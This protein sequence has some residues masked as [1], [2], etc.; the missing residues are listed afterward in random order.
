MKRV[1][2][3]GSSGGNLHRL[4]GADPAQLIRIVQKQL[5]KAGV[6]LKAACFV[7]ADASLDAVTE[8]ATGSLWELHDGA[9]HLVEA[10]RLAKINELAQDQDAAIAELIGSGEVDGV[11]LISADPHGTNQASVAAAAA[12]RLPAAGSGG[13]S[14]AAAE[15]LGIRFVSASGTTGTTNHTRAISYT[16]GFAR[17]W[18]LKYRPVDLPTSPAGWWRR[19]DPRPV[20][21]DALPAI[22]A[23]AVGVGIAQFFGAGTR[24]HLVGLLVPLVLVSISYTASSR[25]GSVGQAGH[26]AGVL[27]GVLA[28]NGGVLTALVAGF[29]AGTLADLAASGAL[30]H[31]V[32]ATG[33]NIIASGGAGLVAGALARLLLSGPGHALDHWCARALSFGLTHAGVWIGAAVGACMWWVL[34]RGYYHSFVL[35]LMVVEFSAGGTSFLAAIDM[36]ALVAVSA[37]VA[38]AAIL[39][40]RTPGDRKPARRTLGIN[41]LLGTYVEG[42]FPHVRAGRAAQAVAVVAATAG[43]AVVGACHGM[44]VTYVP[45]FALPVVGTAH[46]GL[47]AAL[48]VSAG[49]ALCGFATLNLRARRQAV[50]ATTEQHP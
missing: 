1:V 7:S 46:F 41:S 14:V 29:L 48:L 12:H 11:I 43:G 28:S 17:E 35:P 44:G 32:P 30:R 42:S 27:A 34:L 40:P 3:L 6:E 21:V 19:Y 4:G 23:I 18:K 39:L 33:A 13:S 47:L 31:R 20:L 25:V 26:I 50:T 2:L 15:A 22:L 38:A 10:G 5:R 16:S 49:I 37:G 45:L 8:T 24:D 36:V 9:P